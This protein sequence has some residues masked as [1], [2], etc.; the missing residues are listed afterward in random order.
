LGPERKTLFENEISPND[1]PVVC[2]KAIDNIEHIVIAFHNDI[3]VG[4]S[5]Y[6]KYKNGFLGSRLP[7]IHGFV[8]VRYDYQGKGIGS[9]L[10]KIQFEYLKKKWYIWDSQVK[11]GNMPVLRINKRNGF[12]VAGKDDSF[13]YSFMPTRA[14]LKILTPIIFVIFRL[15]KIEYKK[16]RKFISHIFQAHGSRKN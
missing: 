2:E 9:N 5:S 10:T 14:E 15:Y 6:S 12:T 13:Y 11:I 7:F 1:Y 3:I 16:I 8:V 4:V